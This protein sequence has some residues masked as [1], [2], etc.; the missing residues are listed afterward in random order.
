VLTAMSARRRLTEPGNTLHTMQ[1][2]QPMSQAD[3]DR[4]VTETAVGSV[5]VVS[6]ENPDENLKIIRTELKKA[7]IA[8]KRSQPS[9]GCSWI[10]ST[11]SWKQITRKW[12]SKGAVFRT[13]FRMGTITVRTLPLLLESKV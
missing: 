3:Y 4:A 8:I 12:L 11:E 13:S 5:T 1:L 7:G 2:L 10:P 6:G 9:T